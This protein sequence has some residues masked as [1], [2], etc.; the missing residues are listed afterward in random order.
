MSACSRRPRAALAA[1]VLAAAAAGCGD[2]A[3]PPTAP[4]PPPPGVVEVFPAARTARVPFAV[5]PWAR[6]DVAL[7]S[8][9]V[10]EQTVFLKLDTRRLDCDVR[11][12]AAT[13]R[14]V[15]HPLEEPTIARTH[16]VVLSTAIRTAA[17]EPLAHAYEWQFRVVGVRDPAPLVPD[18]GATYESP[19]AAP[20]WTPTES[21]AGDV[22]YEFHA[23]PDSAT[24]AA[25]LGPPL[26]VH[27]YAVFLP[28]TAWALGSRV[29]WAVSTVNRTL[30]ER[31]DGP[32]SR[33]DVLPAGTPTDSVGFQIVRYG[34]RSSTGSGS[35][36]QSSINCGP[37]YNTAMVW[38]SATVTARR[39]ASARVEANISD[40][41]QL[42]SLY[43][44]DRAFDVCA[45]QFPGPPFPDPAL[46]RLA[47]STRAAGSR[48]LFFQ[49]VPLTAQVE[50][51]LRGRAFPGFLPQTG[52]TVDLY[53]GIF[54]PQPPSIRIVYYV[55]PPGTT[56]PAAARD[57]ASG[58]PARAIG[59]A[60]PAL[61][62][63]VT[64]HRA[65]GVGARR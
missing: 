50:R 46:P 41:T 18:P 12:E 65:A 53:G 25:R 19:V 36:N 8:T 55:V 31:S 27:P 2:D 38:N 13:N 10:N 48:R 33:F 4:P 49:S 34:H 51:T 39:I 29:W 22:V 59:G 42:V 5:E 63:S 40:T 30:G 16:T 47:R 52:R 62:P 45:L 7:D 37:G 32:V 58:Q 11:W 1:L 54:A 15:V 43:G 17:G 26:R 56:E 3:S 35:C 44:P 9:T 21:A 64:R 20:E 23:G 28:D 6:F 61:D 14:I 57:D 24:V 60:R